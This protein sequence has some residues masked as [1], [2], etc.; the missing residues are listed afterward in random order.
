MRWPLVDPFAI[1]PGEI[2]LVLV[3]TDPLE[4]SGIVE[5]LL[6]FCPYSDHVRCSPSRENDRSMVDNRTRFMYVACYTN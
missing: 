6:V 5:R 4:Q 3:S 1:V 2:C